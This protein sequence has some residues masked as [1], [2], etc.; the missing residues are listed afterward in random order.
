VTVTLHVDAAVWRAHQDAV[1]ADTPGLVPVVKGNGY[2][3]GR[4]L[5]AAEAARLGVPALA[6]GTAPEV[7]SVRGAFPGDVLVLSP[8]HPAVE[9]VPDDDPQVVRTVSSLAGLEG[10]ASTARSGATAGRRV[11]VELMTSMRRHGLTVEDLPALRPLLEGLTVEGFALHL[12]IDPGDLTRV[13]EVEASIARLWGAGLAVDTL[14]LSHL[15]PDEVAAVQSSHPDVRLLSRVGTRLWL[16][17]RAAYAPRSTVLDVHPL[18]RGDRFGYRQRRAPGTGHLLVVGGGTS[19]G[20]GLEAPRQVRGLGQR[21]KVAAAGGLEAA[22]RALSP[23]TVGDRKRWFAEPPHMQVSLVWLPDD[24][25]PPAIGTELDV[26]VRM[27]TV[28]FD[29]V[30]LGDQSLTSA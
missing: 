3:F 20:I 4:D 19:H 8:W 24:V 2:G 28:T 29:R 15:S 27:T 22:G 5:L 23:F 21:A 30:L 10:L 14:W 18:R 26:E 25:E 12:P 13:E 11:V 16:G 6:V 1:L 17:E 7:A 9:L